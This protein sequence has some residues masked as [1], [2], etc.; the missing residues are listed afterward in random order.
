MGANIF[1]K[2]T[3]TSSEIPEGIANGDLSHQDMKMY[4]GDY[5]KLS[6]SVNQIKNN[7]NRIHRNSE[8]CATVSEKL[9]DLNGLTNTGTE[10]MNALVNEVMEIER[11]SADI[12]K[13]AS[14]IESIAFQ[15]NILALNASVEAARAGDSGSGFAVVAEEV[16][17]LAAKSSNEAQKTSELI[18]RCISHIVKSKECAIQTAELSSQAEKLQKMVGRFRTQ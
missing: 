10:E 8:N 11:M 16:R 4:Q 13:I 6:S 7:S 15:T 5:N 12:Q 9:T 14:T 17:E 18:E 3:S 1:K 2:N